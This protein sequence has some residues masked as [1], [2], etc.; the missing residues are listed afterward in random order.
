MLKQYDKVI[1]IYEELEDKSI[2]EN[3]DTYETL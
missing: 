3:L 2:T 1:L